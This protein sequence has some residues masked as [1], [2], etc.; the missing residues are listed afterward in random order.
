MRRAW[1]GASEAALE[2]MGAFYQPVDKKEIDRIIANVR[3]QLDEATFQAAWVEG[4]AMTLEQAVADAL[5]S[6]EQ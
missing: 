3:S 6:H 2:R 4:R 1:L 5:R